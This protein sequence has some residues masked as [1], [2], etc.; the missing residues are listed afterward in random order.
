MQSLIGL[1]QA[2]LGAEGVHRQMLIGTGA[3]CRCVLG[4]YWGSSEHLKRL[5][6][7]IDDLHAGGPQSKSECVGRVNQCSCGHWS[8]HIHKGR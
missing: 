6:P 1:S 5:P 2:H 4:S 7:L 8:Q 3:N